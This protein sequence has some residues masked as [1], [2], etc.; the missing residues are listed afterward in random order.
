MRAR[1]TFEEI[2][3]IDELF[4][5]DPC[6]QMA[7]KRMDRFRGCLLGLAAG[8]AVGTAVEFQPRGSFAP[9][10]DMV[11]GGPFGLRPGQWTDDTSMALCLAASL[12][13]SDGFDPE[14]QAR[15]YL[16]W[17]DQGYMSSNGTCFDIGSTVSGALSRFEASGDPFAG[18][19]HPR[20]AGNGCI[21]RL[22]P[23]P[24]FYAADRAAAV[25]YAA[26]SARTTHG[27]AECLDACRLLSSMLCAAFEGEGKES[28]V[29]G[30][31]DLP[32]TEPKIAAIANGAYLDKP[33]GDIRGSGYVVECLEAALWCFC[34][35]D[36]FEAAV[37]AA[38]NLGDDADTT[39]A[40]CGQLAGAFYGIDGIP[41]RWL[42]RL[43]GRSMIEQM[44]MAL[45]RGRV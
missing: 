25:H 43:A 6:V 13:D 39:A 20:S 36:S 1:E 14:D 29:R 18:S 12:V 22:A 16:R 35:T 33:A 41:A 23:V 42:N 17:R 38:A 27:A 10:T 7:D 31:D 11:G 19:D 45:D 26:E 32:L 34:H 15:R 24:M 2:A 5:L 44:A 8:D 4:H 37:L 40:V 3:M 21:M 30:H 28:V 9:L